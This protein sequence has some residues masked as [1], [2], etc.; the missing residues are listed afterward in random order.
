MI[1]VSIEDPSQVIGRKPDAK[2]LAR[3]RRFVELNRDTLLQYWHSNTM[4][5]DEF[6]HRLRPIE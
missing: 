5:T 2:L 6:Q 1:S 4:T 3:V